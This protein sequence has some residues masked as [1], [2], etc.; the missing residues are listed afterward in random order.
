[1]ICYHINTLCCKVITHITLV[2]NG[3]YGRCSSYLVYF[4][5]GRDTILLMVWYQFRGDQ[6]L[7]LLFINDLC[8]ISIIFCLKLLGII[9]LGV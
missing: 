9:I 4:V 8:T 7:W 3:G 1:M 2:L 6:S 5:I